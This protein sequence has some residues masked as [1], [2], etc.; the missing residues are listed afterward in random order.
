ME[1]ISEVISIRIWISIASVAAAILVFLAPVS[2]QI[3]DSGPR[4][5]SADTRLEIPEYSSTEEIVFELVVPF[6]VIFFVNRL[7]LQQGLPLILG[8]PGPRRDEPDQGEINRY[9]TI[10]ALAFTSSL[11][12]T[13]LWG[14]I[15]GLSNLIGTIPIGVVSLLVLFFAYKALR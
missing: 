12:P 14:F 13:S 9:A 1:T 5:D 10:L 2:A 11:I 6:M 8:E 7:A 3:L 15:T 4:P